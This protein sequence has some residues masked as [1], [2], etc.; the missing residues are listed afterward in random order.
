MVPGV[1]HDARAVD[2]TPHAHRIAI[3][4]LLDDDRDGRSHQGNASRTLQHP[5]P[6]HETDIGEAFDP[7]A[8]TDDAERQADDDRG[9]GLV[10]AVAVVMSGITGFCRD[11][12]EGN[13]HHVGGQVGERVDGI[14]HHG[15]TSAQY[16]GRKFQQRQ[17]EVDHEPDKGDVVDFPFPNFRFVRHKLNRLAVWT[18]VKSTKKFDSWRRKKSRP[19]RKSVP[20]PQSPT[21]ARFRLREKGR[22]PNRMPP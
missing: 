2:R 4:D 12:R 6:E 10:F 19:A 8:D 7:D 9:Q 17:H 22:H 15:A 5:T 20:E 14:G 11:A 21:G 1:R 18:G 13:H 16:A 3:K